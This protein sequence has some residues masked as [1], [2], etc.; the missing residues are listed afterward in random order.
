MSNT[1]VAI[2]PDGDTLVILAIKQDPHP[3]STEPSDSANSTEP[4]EPA[5]TPDS[6]EF[7]EKHFLCSKKHLTLASRRASKLFSSAFKEASKQDDGLYHWNFGEVFDAQ[8]FELVLKIIHGKTRGLPQNAE[9]DLLSRIASI[10]DDLECHDALSFFT[11]TWLS[12]YGWLYTLPQRMDKTLA[13]LI[14]VS[15]VFAN[16]NLFQKCTQRAARYT[17]EGMPTFDLPIRADIPSRIEESRTEILQYLVDGLYK[18]QDDL[19]HRKLGCSEGCRAMLLGSLLQVMRAVSLYPRPES[20]FYSL[21]LDLIISSLRDMQSSMYYSSVAE[22]PAGKHP[23]TW[24]LHDQPTSP[25]ATQF[26]A[27]TTQSTSSLFGSG[28]SHFVTSTTA[29]NTSDPRPAF[30]GLFGRGA[31]SRNDTTPRAASGGLFDTSTTTQSTPTPNATSSSGFGGSAA[32]QRDNPTSRTASGGSFGASTVSQ[33]TPTFGGGFGAA[34]AAQNNTTPRTTSG[35]FGAKPQP[36]STLA[37]PSGGLFGARTV[38]QTDNASRSAS[39]L[40]ADSLFGNSATAGASSTPQTS[41]PSSTAST[42]NEEA[43]KKIVQHSCCLKSFIDPLLLVAE[44]KI[45]GLNLADFP[46]P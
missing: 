41:D 37:A 27:V 17:S 24:L 14:L 9:L 7:I 28:F 34:P 39:H 12:S 42:K 3:P 13:Q 36:T 2:D 44:S 21:R 25:P 16:E 43:P 22:S 40:P 5:G 30:G 20:P 31:A 4:A 23:G 29:Q 45:Q 26:N 11:E 46:Q 35:I 38:P 1:C 6:P 15:F 10:V 33:S 8:A 32:P 18:V 19:L